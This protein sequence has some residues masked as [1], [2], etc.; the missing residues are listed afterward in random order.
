MLVALLAAASITA[1]APTSTTEGAGQAANV[2]PPA[3]EKKIC[4]RE[5]ATGTKFGKRVCMTESEYKQRAEE[6]KRMLDE[7]QRAGHSTNSP[8]GN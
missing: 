8:S 4:R 3:K 5:A 6:S 1:A 7:M 2:Q